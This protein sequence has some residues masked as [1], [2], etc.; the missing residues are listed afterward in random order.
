MFYGKNVHEKNA[1]LFIKEKILM[2]EIFLIFY[3]IF[4]MLWTFLGEIFFLQVHSFPKINNT[5]SGSVY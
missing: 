1:Q 3:N 5:C 4:A 2:K